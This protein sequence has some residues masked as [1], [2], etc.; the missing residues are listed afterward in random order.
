MRICRIAALGAL[1]VLGL[2]GGV[3]PKAQAAFVATI[4]QVGSNVVVTGSGTINLGGLSLQTSGLAISSMEPAAGSLVIVTSVFTGLYS[5][6]VSGPSAFGS[7]GQTISNSSSGAPAGIFV[8]SY[9]DLI[10]PSDYVS[11]TDLSDSSTYDNA[12]FATL[13]L[14]PGTYTWTFGSVA[15]SDADSFTIQV[16]APVPEPG[17]VVLLATALA[18]LGFGRRRRT[19]A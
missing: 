17:S 16:G 4:E 2:G 15:D 10:F 12:T 14:S 6:I 1:A 9:N 8:S 18:A 3:V 5:G 13:G 7:G 19:V 11:G